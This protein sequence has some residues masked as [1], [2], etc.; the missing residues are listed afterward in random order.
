[1]DVFDISD[2]INIYD[3]SKAPD[4]PGLYVWYARFQV[5]E[6]DW[7]AEY[8]DGD[9]MAKMRL[10]KAIREH[11][12]KFG[13]QEMRVHASANFSS[14][15]KGLLTED[16]AERWQGLQ[17]NG[18]TDDYEEKIRKAVHRNDARKVLV[19]LLNQCFPLFCSPL[20]LG[21]AVEQTLRARLKQHRNSFLDL[22]ERCYKD[23]QLIE[24]LGKPKTFAERALKL[25]FSP[26][27]LFC[28]TMSVDR[29]RTANLTS[30]EIASLID[31]SEWILNR[32]STP[33]LG[34]Q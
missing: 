4:L 5:G 22:W 30:E 21:K 3:V 18:E 13:R 8:A 17:G 23:R 20:Y 19:G 15:W 9:E 31:I 25:G 28:I 2:P 16:V 7:N 29:K 11:S 27:D 24:R 26:D 1:M 32:W 14:V 10:L 6:A 33:I 12:L 34:K